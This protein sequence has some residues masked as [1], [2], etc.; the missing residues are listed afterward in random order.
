M[1]HLP[2]GGADAVVVKHEFTNV[3]TQLRS[4]IRKD[5]VGLFFS[6]AGLNIATFGLLLAAIK[7][8]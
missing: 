6:I 5:H 2:V 1:Q 3:L 4:D 8:I 7:W